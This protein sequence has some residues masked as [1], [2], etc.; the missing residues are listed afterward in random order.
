[1]L[2]LDFNNHITRENMWR[3]Q[4][5]LNYL[6]LIPV[7]GGLALGPD[8]FYYSEVCNADIQNFLRDNLNQMHFFLSDIMN[9]FCEAEGK[10]TMLP[11]LT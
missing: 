5:M 10:N 3:T 1:M 11:N 2:Q 9:I 4:N 8:D 6:S 7:R